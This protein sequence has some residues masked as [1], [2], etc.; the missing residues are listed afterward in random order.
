VIGHTPASKALLTKAGVEPDD[1]VLS[2]IDVRKTSCD[3]KW[4]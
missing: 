2:T 3:L 4:S 1:G